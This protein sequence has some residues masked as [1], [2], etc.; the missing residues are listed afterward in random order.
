M[1]RRST[2]AGAGER[3]READGPPE[4]RSTL[5]T[6]QNTGANIE[7]EYMRER[8]GGMAEDDSFM[9]TFEARLE[10]ELRSTLAET[11]EKESKYDNK[12]NPRFKDAST[13]TLYR[14]FY[15]REKGRWFRILLTIVFITSLVW[16]I[17]NGVAGT[18]YRGSRRVYFG[19]GIF[20]LVVYF[21]LLICTKNT[22]L[23]D[24][25]WMAVSLVYAS[26]T[27]GQLILIGGEA[28]QASPQAKIGLLLAAQIVTYSLAPLPFVVAA[29]LGFVSSVA[30]QIVAASLAVSHTD[31][32][33]S[34]IACNLLAFLCVNSLGLYY[35]VAGDLSSRRTFLQAREFARVQSKVK[36]KSGVP[37]K[38]LQS[39]LPRVMA[40]RLT[41]EMKFNQRQYTSL[42]GT[43]VVWMDNVSILFA[44]VVGF[45]VLS[46]T[47]SA[48][49][50]V[51]L[52]S[53]LFNKFDEL[54]DKNG[55]E[56]IKTLGDCYFLVCGVPE[57]VEDHADRVVQMG[58]EMMITL[59]RF[60]ARKRVPISMR[61]GVHTGSVLAGVI[62]IKKFHYDVWSSDVTIASLMES[63]G[64]PGRVKISEATRAASDTGYGLELAPRNSEH[65]LLANLP[66]YFVL[67]R[68]LESGVEI[69]TD[70][71]NEERAKWARALQ[72]M[73]DHEVPPEPTSP[74]AI[75][76]HS[77]PSSPAA[78]RAGADASQV[79]G[80]G[81][82]VAALERRPRSVIEE[83][84]SGGVHAAGSLDTT[85]PEGRDSMGVVVV[86]VDRVP[87]AVDMSAAASEARMARRRNRGSI[88]LSHRGDL[89]ATI[90]ATHNPK[91][92]P[93][94][95]MEALAAEAGA[96]DENHVGTITVETRDS[97]ASSQSSADMSLLLE[98]GRMAVD[99]SAAACE[100]ELAVASI[101]A[102]T[103]QRRPTGTVFFTS[104]GGTVHEVACVELAPIVAT[105]DADD[106]DNGMCADVSVV[107]GARGVG[108]VVV[109]V[110]A[111]DQG[112]PVGVGTTTLST[113]N[114]A[115]GTSR[116][117]RTASS[118][119]GGG[120]ECA[121]QG[122]ERSDSGVM[123]GIA[124]MVPDVDFSKKQDEIVMSLK[125]KVNQYLLF[126]TDSQLEK[127][128]QTR[129]IAKQR[130]MKV[131]VTG[132]SMSIVVFLLISAIEVIALPET[133]DMLARFLVI[134]FVLLCI[135]LVATA[136]AFPAI[137]ER[138][139]GC[140]TAEYANKKQPLIV[141]AANYIVHARSLQWLGCLTL[142]LVALQALLAIPDCR[143]GRCTESC[144][145]ASGAA[146]T[147]L[148]HAPNYAAEVA[149]V[150]MLNFT[151]FFR[152]SSAYRSALCMAVMV[153]WLVVANVMYNDVYKHTFPEVLIEM[154]LVTIAV[155]A[156]NWQ[157][158]FSVRLHFLM[159]HALKVEV[160]HAGHVSQR[161]EYLVRN[162]LPSEFDE[163][164]LM[165]S[166]TIAKAR[167]NVAIVFCNICNFSDLFAVSGTK[168]KNDHEPVQSIDLSVEAMRL[169]NEFICEFD[170]M[171]DK[172]KYLSVEKIKTI[173]STYM[174]AAGLPSFKA[175]PK[176][177][178]KSESESDAKFESKSESESDDEDPNSS[179][180]S[181][182]GLYPH[183]YAL[184][185][186][187]LE[188]QRVLDRLNRD[189]FEFSV[190]KSNYF[191]LRIGMNV[192]TVVAGVIGRKK[193]AFD[194]W[195]DAV[196]VA[197]RMESSGEPGR[198]QVTE[199]TYEILKDVYEFERRGTVY[200]K[201]KGDM[202][203]YFLIG[204]R[205]RRM[206]LYIERMIPDHEASKRLSAVIAHNNTPD[207]SRM[208][209]I[210]DLQ[211]QH[212]DHYNSSRKSSDSAPDAAGA[213]IVDSAR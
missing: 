87:S 127:E 39:C 71:S 153:V 114:D 64:T 206:S 173:G 212:D 151:N 201:G 84:T 197:S 200:V 137:Y 124:E 205:K 179:N 181:M 140:A 134:F 91:H 13:E 152:F 17:Y 169:L 32:L 110:T 45:T 176:P 21:A 156:N 111:P 150:A 116:S 210:E 129:Y 149:I 95:V 23:Y 107:N 185:D 10:P 54:A 8:S 138:I 164:R 188:M 119:A 180:P 55:V 75:R 135:L 168:E 51:K 20:S 27:Y 117:M 52:L 33:A 22:A 163:N 12:F 159:K 100:N 19:A 44:D 68:R 198:I 170:E 204:K 89:L 73:A 83:G 112:L 155:V 109:N 38:I 106:C 166:K 80:S 86:D 186:F 161:T 62:G 192:G 183:I 74:A 162:L 101:D 104:R 50:L 178:P 103:H 145:D 9:E 43:E 171:C 105:A 189:C 207:T 172:M 63:T 65:P 202:T 199:W 191:A 15:L 160:W 72:E 167:D 141:R 211:R 193:I 182:P 157:M 57:P 77:T 97:T 3:L 158:E 2:D 187:V 208:I 120:R 70:L 24:R 92:T 213:G 94:A 96:A 30:H 5:F 93:A 18:E 108:G 37:L 78:G 7:V 36:E 90:D 11:I 34:Q 56:K 143:D 60:A 42:R 35:A 154:V 26:V 82:Q 136:K 53:A 194:I 40:E 99:G 88:I 130:G 177:K 1:A 195:G 85:T 113:G 69:I 133:T 132:V 66:A 144:V 58:L 41:K 28:P 29:L 118:I 148:S 126:F 76:A 142:C 131:F 6:D 115:G 46:T 16:T 49:A 125:S 59:S 4:R 203:T 47:M 147:C 121:H 67:G 190:D 128:Y 79:Q 98:K 31:N 165:A 122:R 48:K 25:H 61:V 209:T 184:A 174:A 14:Q 102:A 175:K 81:Q 196:N 146:A 123:S 139:C